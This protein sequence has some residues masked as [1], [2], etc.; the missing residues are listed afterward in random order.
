MD[1]KALAAL[2]GPETIEMRRHLHRNPELSNSEEGTVKFI[3]EKLEEYGIEY[4]EVDK[5][6]ILGFIGGAGEG[7]VLLRADIDALPI[8]ENLRN[9]KRERAV[10]SQNDGV[11]H[12]CGHDAHTAML[13]TAAKILSERER[14]GELGPGG[15]VLLFERGEEGTGNLRYLL[16]HIISK[17][18][19]ISAAHAIH[20]RPDL[21]AGRVHIPQGPVMA[22]TAG[23]QVTLRGR[24]GHGSR[25]DRSNNPVDCF[26]AVYNAL[27]S[28]RLRRTSPFEPFTFS[29]GLLSGGDK[30][31]I[32]PS[33]LTFGGSARFYSMEAG[34]AF[35]EEFGR[36]LT[37]TAAAYGMQFDGGDVRLGFPTV[38]HGDLARFAREAALSALGD[39][40]LS[41][42]EP[43]MGSESF[44][45]VAR[46]WPSVMALLGVR[47]VE[48][49]SGADLHSEFFDIDESALQIGVAETVSFAASFLKSRPALSPLPSPDIDDLLAR[50]GGPGL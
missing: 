2:Y 24:G 50:I 14:E 7:A 13:L 20:V 23:F 31:N 6:G 46:L 49:G 12:A 29:I 35:A 3:G 19:R 48:L 9:L 27:V 34:E 16:R 25:P 40:V 26:V 30:G 43:L 33:E 11:Q 44:A 36:V 45:A 8:R 42:G 41:D 28:I 38:N 39:G 37:G 5:G 1:I 21:D 10:I 32:I 22:G 15:A 47:N 4:I 18:M 17:G